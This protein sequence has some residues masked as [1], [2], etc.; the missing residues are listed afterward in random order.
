LQPPAKARTFQGLDALHELLSTQVMPMGLRCNALAEPRLHQ[1]APM[2]LGGILLP[3]LLG[4]PPFAVGLPL[5][6][7]EAQQEDFLLGTSSLLGKHL[8]SFL[9]VNLWEN[10]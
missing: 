8:P 2:L 5:W 10:K 7:Q 4:I 9:P 1:S 3:L 6:H